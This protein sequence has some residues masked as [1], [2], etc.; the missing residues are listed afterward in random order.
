[1]IPLSV[2]VPLAVMLGLA[3]AY[4]IWLW[5]TTGKYAKPRPEKK[6]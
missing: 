4:F 6:D 2:L 1:M 3:T 5:F